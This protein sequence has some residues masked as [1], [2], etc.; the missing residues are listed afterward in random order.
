MVNGPVLLRA[1]KRADFSAWALLREKSREQLTPWENDW[2]AQA[3]SKQQYYRR[4]RAYDYARKRGRAVPLF[5]FLGEGGPLIGGVTL[6]EIARGPRQSATLSY[7]I[8]APFMRQGFGA[9]AVTAM[10]EHSFGR[11]GLRRVEAACHPSNAPSKALLTK[12]GFAH[13]G[14]AEDYL[15]INGSWQDHDRFALTAKAH[16]NPV[17][18]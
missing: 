15:E 2:D 7:W 14:R 13:E 12:L 1:P 5:V 9:A 4:L 11:L 6:S 17:T 10:V 16:N 18:R 3:L 8:G